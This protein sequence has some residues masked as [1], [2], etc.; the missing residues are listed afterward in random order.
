MKLTIRFRFRVPLVRT[1]YLHIAATSG[2]NPRCRLFVS[3]PVCSPSA[4]F[5][6]TTTATATTLS[7][8]FTDAHIVRQCARV[9]TMLARAC[10]SLITC[11]KKQRVRMY[12]AKTRLARMATYRCPLPAVAIIVASNIVGGHRSVI[13]PANGGGSLLSAVCYRVRRFNQEALGHIIKFRFAC[14]FLQ[15]IFVGCAWN[16]YYSVVDRTKTRAHNRFFLSLTHTEKRAR[17]H[18]RLS[19]ARASDA[20][21]DNTMLITLIVVIIIIDKI[22]NMHFYRLIY[23]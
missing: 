22:I 1:C 3:F 19:H 20:R 16:A 18:F 6:I 7:L 21:I 8:S 12:F 13:T 4:K 14:R 10:V 5:T 11:P 17:R 23:R 15:R 9:F 2:R